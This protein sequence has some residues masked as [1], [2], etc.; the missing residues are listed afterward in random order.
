LRNASTVYLT[1]TDTTMGFISQSAER[2]TQ[3]KQRPPHKHY[4]KALP[5]LRSLTAQVR[6]PENYKNMIRRSTRSTFIFPDTHSYRVI[7]VQRHRAL[8]EKLGWAYTTSANPS[9]GDFDK[10]FAERAAD[11]LIAYPDVPGEKRASSIFKLNN[12]TMRRYR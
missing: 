3:I 4:I 1:P 8:I 2:L 11:V 6:I 12:I 9:G 7:R 5:S 10:N